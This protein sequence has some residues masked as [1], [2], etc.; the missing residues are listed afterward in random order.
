MWLVLTRFVD[1]GEASWRGDSSYDTKERAV[2][3][4]KRMALSGE[5]LILVVEVS[6]GFRGYANIDTIDPSDIVIR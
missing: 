6:V 2:A 4:A 5:N 3:V 1:S